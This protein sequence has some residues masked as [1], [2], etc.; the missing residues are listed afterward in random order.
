MWTLTTGVISIPGDSL[1]EFSRTRA[2]M[3]IVMHSTIDTKQV[4]TANVL[5]IQ[6]GIFN[7]LIPAA[8]RTVA[9]D[10]YIQ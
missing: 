3:K 9:Y 5:S 8:S 1:K 10:G 6:P 4:T 2:M 7:T